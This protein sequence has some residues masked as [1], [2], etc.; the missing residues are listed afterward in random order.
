MVKGFGAYAM[1]DG[2]M[3]VGVLVS[4]AIATMIVWL[5]NRCMVLNN[6]KEIFIF[7]F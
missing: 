2:K 1:M 3:V 4:L 6:C 5:V 7:I